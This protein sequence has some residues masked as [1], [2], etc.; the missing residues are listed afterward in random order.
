M[1]RRI[2]GIIGCRDKTSYCMFVSCIP[3]NQLKSYEIPQVC[4]VWKELVPF[5]LS[6]C[7]ESTSCVLSFRMVFFYLVTT[8]WIFDISLCE[9]S[10]KFIQSKSM[11]GHHLNCS[12]IVAWHLEFV[13][14][15]L[16]GSCSEIGNRKFDIAAFTILYY[17]S[18]V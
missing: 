9:S 10:T 4:T 15:G 2:G 7:I 12:S 18:I 17:F 1:L 6:L 16:M 11:Y 13:I 3:Q 14:S 8:G 5:P